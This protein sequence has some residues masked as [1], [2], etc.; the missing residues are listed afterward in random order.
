MGRKFVGMEGGSTGLFVE[1]GILTHDVQNTNE[2]KKD[3]CS[4]AVA[5]SVV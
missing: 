2:R 4:M 1:V 5:V 3:I